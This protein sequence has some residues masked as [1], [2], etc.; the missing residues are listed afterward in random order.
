MSVAERQGVLWPFFG[1]A[2]WALAFA[3][4]PVAWIM[5]SIR[6]RHLRNSELAS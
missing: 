3:V 1:L 4:L 2:G 6:Q 5:Q